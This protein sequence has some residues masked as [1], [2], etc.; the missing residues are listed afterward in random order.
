LR[1]IIVF[2]EAKRIFDVNKER[3]PVEGIPNIDILTSRVRE[4]G[5]GLIVSDQEWSKLTDSIK[6]NSFVKVIFR[7]GSGKDI[8]DAARSIGLE[9]RDFVGK[10]RTGEA[11]VKVGELNPFLIQIPLAGVEK[12]KADLLINDRF[13]R[14]NKQIFP[15]SSLDKLSEEERMFLQDILLCPLSN[16]TERYRRL[17]LN[18]KTGNRMKEKLAQT[19]LVKETT[20]KDGRKITLLELT[21]KASILLG[22]NPKKSWRKGGVEHQYWVKKVAED[23]R[24]KGYRVE[25]EVPIGEGKSVDVVA[26]KDGKRIAIEVE[27]GK[28]DVERN[29]KNCMEAGFDDV[30]VVNI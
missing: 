22:S 18:P 16:V 29:V 25:E 28:S 17:D 15:F 8:E 4:F 23:Y 1:H 9:R 6:A 3:R 7:L 5:E 11:I 12:E 13:P 24:K 14:Q 20:I 21:P 30:R 26:V 2:D 10:L 27:T 19:G